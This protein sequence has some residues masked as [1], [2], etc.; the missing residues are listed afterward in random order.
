MLGTVLNITPVKYAV[1]YHYT[2]KLP[3]ILFWLI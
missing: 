3:G 1:V 2:N